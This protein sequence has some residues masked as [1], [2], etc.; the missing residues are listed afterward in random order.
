MIGL[1]FVNQVLPRPVPYQTR[2]SLFACCI[3]I[4]LSWESSSG[5]IFW[6]NPHPLKSCLF[7]SFPVVSLTSYH[8]VFCLFKATKQK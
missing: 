8:W 3:I 6:T 7:L 5:T 1:G 4:L 2:I